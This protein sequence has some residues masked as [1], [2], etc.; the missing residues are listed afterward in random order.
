[1][2]ACENELILS[3][4]FGVVVFGIEQLLAASSCDANSS[5]EF[6]LNLIRSKKNQCITLKDESPLDCVE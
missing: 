6:I 4:V 5:T 1:M 3:C 2:D